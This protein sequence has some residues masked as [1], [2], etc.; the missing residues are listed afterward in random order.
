MMGKMKRILLLFCKNVVI[1]KRNS[2]QKQTVEYENV[3]YGGVHILKRRT[4]THKGAVAFHLGTISRTIIAQIRA[5][6]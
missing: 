6:G 2:S 5:D 1:V 3:N 4:H